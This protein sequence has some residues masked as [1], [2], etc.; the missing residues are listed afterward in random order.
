MNNDIVYEISTYLSGNDYL[1]IRLV[2]RTIYDDMIGLCVEHLYDDDNYKYIKYLSYKKIYKLA[3]KQYDVDP[4]VAMLNPDL[5]LQYAKHIIK[6]RWPPGEPIIMTDPKTMSLYAELVI[7]G[8][9]P[10]AVN[11]MMTDTCS[12]YHYY[13]YIGFDKMPEDAFDLICT[14]PEYSLMYMKK[15]GGNDRMIKLML[16][17]P[18]YACKYAVELLID[19]WPEAESIIMQDIE[20]LAYYVRELY[21]GIRVP[22]FEKILF[23]NAAIAFKYTFRLGTGRIQ[24]AEPAILTNITYSCLY[25]TEIIRDVWPELD[26]IILN[27]TNNDLFYAIDYIRRHIKKR[28]PEF[29]KLVFNH[30]ACVFTYVSSV[31]TF[32]NTFE[33]NEEI[34]NLM[35]SDGILVYAK[36]T[37]QGR[38]PLGEQIL[39]QRG[40]AIHL[41]IYA[42]EIIH[43]R[44]VEAESIIRINSSAAYEYARYVINDRWPEG[45]EAISKNCY[46]SCRYCRNVL[47]ARW[48]EIEYKYGMNKR[49]ITYFKE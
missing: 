8:P 44:W 36:R 30:S 26:A 27:S 12:I 47:N 21:R 23:T 29:E 4:N 34:A 46:I 33:I 32:D 5:S 48:P 17:S 49:Y 40:V 31:I 22:E 45:E 3:M 43:D 18:Q 24:E 11:L 35:H 13:D 1:S 7:K 15:V 10:E 37:I 6:G 38:W 25:A 28:I 39:L 19:K 20:Y 9:W 41:M 42:N 14:S 2:F 16:T